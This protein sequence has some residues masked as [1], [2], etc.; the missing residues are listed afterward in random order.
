MNDSLGWLLITLSSFTSLAIDYSRPRLE[1]KLPQQA[2]KQNMNGM[3]GMI[4]SLITIA[5][6]AGIMYV[7]L[8]VLGLHAIIVGIS[9]VVVSA[10]SLIPAWKVVVKAAGRCYAAA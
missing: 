1:W 2:V 7:L 5:I 6:F 4:V 10:L 8:I 3:L 9:L